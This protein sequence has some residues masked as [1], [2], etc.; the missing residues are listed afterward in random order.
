MKIGILT[1]PLWA[2]YGGIIQNYALQQAL[3]QLGHEPVTIRPGNKYPLWRYYYTCTRLRLCKLFGASSIEFPPRPYKGRFVPC[4]HLWKFI[5]KNIRV[6]DYRAEYSLN[7]IKKLKLDAIVVGSDQVWR[8]RYNKMTLETM[9][10]SFIPKNNTIKRVAYAASF[11]SDEWE[12]TD[13]QTMTCR[14]LV[15]RFDAVSVREDSGVTLCKEHFDIDAVHVLD[16]TL[17]LDKEHY[18]KLCVDVPSQKKCLCAYILD[19]SEREREALETIAAERYLELKVFSADGDCTLTIEQWLAIFRDAEMVI[20][21]SFHGTVFSIIF[22]KEFYSVTHPIR[23]GSRIPSLFRQ[24]G[25]PQNRIVTDIRQIPTNNSTPLDW[26]VIN[27]RI[28]EHQQHSITF[29]QNALTSD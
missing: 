8:P 11:G 5:G 1:Q 28:N 10:L 14:E 12:Y 23:G 24:L 15:Q 19:L 2:N 18:S 20:T 25:I 9:F 17:L 16:P 26:N 7:Y 21:N 29:L 3:K 4:Y 13:E 6:T 27:A 22:N